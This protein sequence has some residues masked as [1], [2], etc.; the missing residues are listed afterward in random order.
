MAKKRPSTALPKIEGFERIKYQGPA[1][2]GLSSRVY[3]S[4]M[5]KPRRIIDAYNLLYCRGKQK[6]PSTGRISNATRELLEANFLDL[7]QT[8][9]SNWP[10][11]S[12]NLEPLFGL[13]QARKIRLDDKERKKLSKALVPDYESAER[14]GISEDEAQGKS[15]YVPS[16]LKMLR[17]LNSASML[18]LLSLARQQQPDFKEERELLS[19]IK[20]RTMGLTE[21][22][23]EIREEDLSTIGAFS[24]D[25]ALKARVG[26]KSGEDPRSLLFFKL[27]RLEH[28]PTEADAIEAEILALFE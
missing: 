9:G 7:Y 8:E 5:G 11:Y 27:L 26:L 28:E 15:E 1:L 3:S 16:P 22:K 13:F 25:L 10:L 12:A 4:Y 6:M 21:K 24:D 20:S 17:Y 2:S 19:R 14:F 18:A 23:D